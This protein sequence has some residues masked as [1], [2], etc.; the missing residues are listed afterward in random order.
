M[1][2]DDAARG[3]EGELGAEK[4]EGASCIRKRRRVAD[5]T[6]IVRVQGC[7]VGLCVVV[8]VV[9]SSGVEVLGMSRARKGGA[10]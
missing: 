10:G 1:G 8:R 9:A 4:A 7:G 5:K 3:R 6:F 2:P